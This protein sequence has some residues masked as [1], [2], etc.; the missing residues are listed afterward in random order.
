M[1][2]VV[3]L[4][5]G[6]TA[7][8]CVLD[9][10]VTSL[11]SHEA[12]PEELILTGPLE[13]LSSALKE[14]QLDTVQFIDAPQV[15]SMGDSPR[16]AVREKKD[17]SIT[18]GINA[19]ADSQADAFISCGN[20]GAI[21]AAAS[22]LLGRL[23]G[24]K[25]PGIA[26]PMPTESGPCVVIDVGANIY[27]KPEHLYQYALMAAEYSKAALGQENPTIGLLN[28][29]EEKEKGHSL[30]Q[31]TD[32]RLK[33]LGDCYLGFIEGQDVMRGVA[34]VVV[35]EGFVGNVI[36]KI[37][38]GVGSFICKRVTAALSSIES[39][40]EISSCLAEAFQSL[41]HAAYGGAPLLGVNAPV[42]IGHGRS[43]ARAVS[44]MIRASKAAIRYDVNS[45]ITERLK[46]MTSEA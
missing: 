16:T 45:H 46:T 10:V 43:D 30:I 32:E 26:V 17:S 42:L 15:I 24:V 37:A 27:C 29:G 36:L 1:K 22:L 40:A 12:D 38:E 21:V 13:M 33:T 41:D 25:R 18:K 19:V 20:T 23:E 34:D 44:N 11:E 2:I 8:D 31:E 7:P 9:G 6:D 4:M 3:D 5:G 35:C 28:I 14:R 39:N